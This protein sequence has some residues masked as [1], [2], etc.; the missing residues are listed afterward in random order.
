[1][2]VPAHNESSIIAA[3]VH[4]LRGQL[5]AGDVLLVVAD[6][7]EDSTA[8]LATSA[9]ATVIERHDA[10]HRGKGYALSFATDYLKTNGAPDVVVI[11]DADGTVLGSYRKSHIPVGEG[12]HEKF[13]FSPGDTGF[14]VFQTRYAKLGVAI[15][16]DQWFPEAARLAAILPNPHKWKAAH[17]GECVKYALKG[18]ADRYDVIKT[19]H[20]PESE[21]GYHFGQNED[22]WAASFAS[23]KWRSDT[24]ESVRSFIAHFEASPLRSR[25]VGYHPVTGQTGEWN[26]WGAEH[27]PDLSA[28]MVAR[29]G[30]APTKTERLTTTAGLLR[31]PA[32]GE[33]KVV[34]Q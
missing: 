6:N 32:K 1:V 7:C 28:P 26:C 22:L 5:V 12:Y 8:E 10:Q 23:E 27:L 20:L 9:G 3:T 33:V 31:D 13:Y 17:P 24:A 11:V 15:C 21:G 19:Q 25:I 16:W 34:P 14:K 2:V 30:P 4:H 29:T 18:P